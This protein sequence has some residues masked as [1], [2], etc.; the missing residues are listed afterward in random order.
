MKDQKSCVSDHSGTQR[1][2]IRLSKTAQ[3]FIGGALVH[4]DFSPMRSTWL[5]ITFILGFRLKNSRCFETNLQYNPS[6]IPVQSPFL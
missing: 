1:F 2:V 5:T 3:E 4:L 6:H